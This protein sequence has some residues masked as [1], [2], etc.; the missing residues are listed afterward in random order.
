MLIKDSAG[1]TKNLTKRYE[2]SNSS[3]S[4]SNF[5]SNKVWWALI[6]CAD[7]HLLSCM[8]SK[9]KIGR[10][11]AHNHS[12][13]LAFAATETRE[14]ITKKKW[15][16]SGLTALTNTTTCCVRSQVFT[17]VLLPQ[18]DSQGGL[19]RDNIVLTHTDSIWSYKPLNHL[20]EEMFYISVSLCLACACVVLV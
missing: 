13:A 18:S 16:P 15:Y 12:P 8:W 20:R 1:K 11:R 17:N 7:T 6:R 5:L 4:H 9:C 14:A 3:C 10:R 19:S 2:N